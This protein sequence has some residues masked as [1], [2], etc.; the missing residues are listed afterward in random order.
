MNVSGEKITSDNNVDSAV[1]LA[2]YIGKTTHVHSSILWRQKNY[3]QTSIRQNTLRERV[4]VC[5]VTRK[6]SGEG[7]ALNNLFS[8]ERKNKA[9]SQPV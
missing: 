7:V 1:L 9:A 4:C 6:G 5:V 3:L 8:A 2:S